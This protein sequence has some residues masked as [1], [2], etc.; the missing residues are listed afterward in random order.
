MG[1]K[2]FGFDFLDPDDQTAVQMIYLR[3]LKQLPSIILYSTIMEIYKPT[4]MNRTYPNVINFEL[5]WNGRS[6]ME[7][8]WKGYA[9][10]M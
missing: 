3:L 10:M 8:P 5:F 6:R 1:V 4:G 9:D 7:H 2:G